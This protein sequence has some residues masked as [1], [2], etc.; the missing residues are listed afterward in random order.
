MYRAAKRKR[1]QGQEPSCQARRIL[2]S[3]PR[4]HD[5]SMLSA[6]DQAGS[7]EQTAIAFSRLQP[8]HSKESSASSNSTKQAPAGAVH[9]AGIAMPLRAQPVHGM[10]ADMSAA[11]AQ[12]AR[13]GKDKSLLLDC[14]RSEE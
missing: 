6:L 2:F 14:M 7:L 9:A 12:P 11:S 4:R 13:Q 8:S 5:I 10:A 3:Q 1:L